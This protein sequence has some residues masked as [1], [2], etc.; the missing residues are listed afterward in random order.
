ML[1]S[2]DG[3]SAVFDDDGVLHVAYNI[4]DS[5]SQVRYGVRSPEGWRIDTIE[6]QNLRPREPDMDIDSN[7]QP[8]LVFVDNGGIGFDGYLATQAAGQW[9]MEIIE[10]FDGSGT[11]YGQAIAVDSSNALAWLV[12]MGRRD[13][14]DAQRGSG[15]SSR[16]GTILVVRISPWMLAI[17]RMWRGSRRSHTHSCIPSARKRDG[18]HGHRADRPDRLGNISIALDPLGNP[19]LAYE[20][21]LDGS[22]R[23]IPRYVFWDGSEWLGDTIGLGDITLISRASHWPLTSP[24]RLTYFSEART[25]A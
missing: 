8:Y 21:D 1:A 5:R 17:G 22:G 13:A 10:P 20:A 7:A 11:F 16:S 9:S 18:S 25:R 4:L 15:R 6:T 2:G 23:T 3:I 14:C 19:H 12:S 24:E